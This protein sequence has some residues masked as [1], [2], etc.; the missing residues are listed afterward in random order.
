MGHTAT[1]FDLAAD[2]PY[3]CD[4]WAKN[5]YFRTAQIFKMPVSN[6]PNL[7]NGSKF[8][9]YMLCYHIFVRVARMTKKREYYHFAQFSNGYKLGFMLAQF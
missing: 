7:S 6:L 1:S 2:M 8:V 9:T 4:A 3:Q 5:D